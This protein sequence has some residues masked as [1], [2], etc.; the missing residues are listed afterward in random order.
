MKF[1]RKTYVQKTK[2]LLEN[3]SVLL[4]VKFSRLNSNYSLTNEN[5]SQRI[6]NIDRS[7]WKQTPVIQIS[8][9]CI[10]FSKKITLN[11]KICQKYEFRQ[12][13]SRT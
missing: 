4:F 6:F 5:L 11:K 12:Y 13:R 10:E 3:Y 7:Y 9:K 8:T 1:W 2:L